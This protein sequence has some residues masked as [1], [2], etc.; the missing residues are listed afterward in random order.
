M[1]SHSIIPAILPKGF[2]DLEQRLS[3]VQGVAPMVQIDVV[4][5]I[6]APTKTW[7][8]VGGD[9]F[10]KI[11]AQEEGLPY[12]EEFDFQFDLMVKDPK[13]EALRFIDAGASGLVIHAANEHAKEALE[14]LQYAR[15]LDVSLGVALLP[16]SMVQ[17]LNAFDNLYDFVQV[18]GIA[19]VGSQGKPFDERT[20]ALVAAL[21][22]EYT[23]LCIQIDGGV[24]L[25]TAQA[26]VRA[27]ATRLVAGSAIFNV[28]N[29]A[30]AYEELYTKTNE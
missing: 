17:D 16:S 6:F 11:I 28:H 22:A 19:D 21:R 3:S 26:L 10:E 27:G 13:T 9:E 12:W 25:A 2:A 7:P 29:P 8:Y 23:E 24:S 1:D 18:M 30:I 20:L 4:D 15:D 5:G 14:S